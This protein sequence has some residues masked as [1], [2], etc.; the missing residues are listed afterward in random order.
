MTVL[1][2]RDTAGAGQTLQSISYTEDIYII[3]ADIVLI[4]DS[5]PDDVIS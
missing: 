5:L 3:G 4:Q 1:L 2:L